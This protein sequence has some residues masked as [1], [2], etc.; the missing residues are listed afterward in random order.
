MGG[1]MT[2]RERLNKILDENEQEY[3]EN[4]IKQHGEKYTYDNLWDILEKQGQDFYNGC[5][6]E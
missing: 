4:Y 5:Q 2:E 6:Y 3:I 1:F